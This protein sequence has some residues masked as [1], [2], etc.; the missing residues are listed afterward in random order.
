M[1]QETKR[2]I[3]IVDDDIDVLDTYAHVFRNVDYDVIEANDGLE[4]LD[5]A[6]KNRPD[7]IFTGIIM[8][9]MDGF[10][11]IEALKKNPLTSSIPFAINS[12]LGR[13]EDK[14]RAE[15]IGAVDFIIRDYTPPREVVERISA[16]LIGG[17]YI[18]EFDPDGGD[19][20]RLAKDLGL[21]NFFQCPDDGKM[22]LRITIKDSHNRRFEATLDCI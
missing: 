18:L 1:T 16:R 6:T 9:R 20:Q 10:T 8:P 19:A 21:E 5:K 17:S 7:I 4:G 14:K 13:E 2:R 22:I 15:E 3:L 12:H 11:M